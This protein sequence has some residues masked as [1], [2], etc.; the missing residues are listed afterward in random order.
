MKLAEYRQKRDQAQTSEP[1]G[2]DPPA[3]VGPTREG[4]FVFHLHAATR[5]HYDLRL[6]LGGVLASFAVPRG[7]S[8]DPAEKRLAVRTEDHPLEYLDFEAVIPE[9]QYGGGPM[10]LWDRGRARYIEMTAEEGLARGKLDFELEGM[11]VRGRFSLVKIK[12]EAKEWLLLKKSDAFASKERD[13]VRDAPRSILS[14]LTV[15]EL[16]RAREIGAELEA[17]AAALGAPVGRFEAKKMVPMLCAQSGAPDH[18]DAWLYE[19]KLDGVRLLAEKDG[20]RAS[21]HGRKLREMTAT[22]PEVARA[23]RSLAPSRVVLDGEVVTFDTSGR[24]SF[25]RLAQR[26][27]LEKAH[28]VKRAMVSVPVVYVAFDVLA[29]GE[30]DLR[31]LPVEARKELLSALLPAPG[32]MRVLDWLDGD[33]R[34]LMAFCA[35]RGLEG[36]VAKRKGSP[37]RP[38]PRRGDEWVKMK[39]ERDED[40]VVVGF[41]RGEGG[42]ERLG[43]LD[44]ASWVDGKLFNRGKVG[45]GIDEPSIDALLARLEPIVTHSQVATGEM[46]PAPRGRTHVKPLVVVRV[47][48]AGFSEGDGQIRHGVFGGIRDDVDPRECTAGPGG[49]G[50]GG[51]EGEREKNG[52]DDGMME[53]APKAAAK[54]RAK[55]RKAAARKAA[56]EPERAPEPERARAPEAEEPLPAITNPN[57]VLWPGEGITK[58]DLC[59]Y[60]RA[61][62]PA[63]L[64]YLRDRPVALVR[65]PDGIAGKSFYQWNVPLGTPE[66]L[67][68]YRMSDGEGSRVEVFIV[69]D[70]RSLAHVANLAAIPIHMLASRASSI[71]ECEFLTLDFDVKGASLREGVTLAISLAEILDRAGLPGF[72]KTSGQSGLHVL[73]PLG[74]GVSYASARA[75]ADLLGR[76]LVHKHPAIATMERIIAKRGPRVYVDTGQTGPTRT[77]VAPWS[78]RATP[79]ARVSVPLR[80]SEVVPDLDPA[81]FTIRTAPARFRDGGDPMSGLLGARPDLGAAL[82]RLEELVQKTRL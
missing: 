74:P 39:R 18:G 3:V 13:P 56:R 14:G 73:V 31:P 25:I 66:W 49:E 72:P 40:F 50:E 15:E 12:G 37:Y 10:I 33:A 63:M 51:E 7:P 58:A 9:G 78:V 5:R 45:S 57:K 27:H 65:Y 38:G 80:W 21:L 17:R 20:V 47:R 62:A 44:V 8:F 77:I 69:D 43:A 16:L 23:V 70:A 55:P 29:I 26:M 64:P 11:K 46:A 82:G 6:E 60:Y 35:E 76:L 32:A 41:T 54:T 67:H 28:E 36:V 52:R 24:P 61:I 19:L 79:G 53:A 22:Y 4:A 2:E 1:F 81:A 34:P 42:R 71:A 30:R 68:T 59:G 48:F 75:M